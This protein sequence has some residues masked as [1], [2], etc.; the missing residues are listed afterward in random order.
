MSRIFK[1]QNT[2]QPYAW[3][4]HVDIAQL[5]G[6]STPSDQPQAELWMG[7]HPK[8]P[9]K[10]WFQGRWQSLDELINEDPVPY[11]GQKTVDRF[12]PQLPFLFKVLAVDQP[13]SLQAH[14]SKE[15]AQIGF[16]RENEE[17]IPLSAPHR[18]YKDNQHKPECVCALTPFHAL[19]GFREAGVIRQLVEPIWPPDRLNEIENLRSDSSDDDIRLFFVHLMTMEKEQRIPLISHVA[20]MSQSLAEQNPAYDWIVRLNETYP[21]DI[22]VF[23]PVVLNLIELQPG[24]ALFLPAG[25]MHAYLKGL[26]VEV[27]ANSDNVLRGGLTPKHVDVKELLKVLEFKSHPVKILEP[28]PAGNIELVYPSS[29]DEFELSVL[30]VKSG[31]PHK[32]GP[33]SDSA[34][35]HLC[36]KGE[37]NFQWSG[38]SKGL[39]IHKGESV[40]VQAEVEHYE[41]YGEAH[42]Y[43][44]EVNTAVTS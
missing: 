4:S 43:K 39:Q 30:N 29:A 40:L 35:V 15:M 36:I 18:N 10:V 14:P 44:V 2:I 3:G 20:G 38:S 42:L 19:C 32:T 5:L 7:A 26:A 27:M 24:Q 34:E 25:R 8:A 37:A 28:V 21:E 16:S 1:L 17:G 6:H 11:L 13:L 23:A 12:G 31:I 9:S 22:G 33:R 41:I